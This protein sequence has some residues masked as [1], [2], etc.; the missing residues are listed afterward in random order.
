MARISSLV[1]STA[2]KTK[3]TVAAT[4]S[5]W[6]TSITVSFFTASGMGVVIFQRPATAS[7]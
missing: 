5:T 6:F 2:L 1:M 3:S 7:S 4:C